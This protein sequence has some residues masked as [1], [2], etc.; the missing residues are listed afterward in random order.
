MTREERE[1][2]KRIEREEAY[3]ERQRRIA[4]QNKDIEEQKKKD[5]IRENEIRR[6]NELRDIISYFLLKF[7]SNCT[8]N[9]ASFTNHYY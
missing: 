4:I 6:Y 9:F 8:R 7:L 3:K 1:E 2:K 5:A